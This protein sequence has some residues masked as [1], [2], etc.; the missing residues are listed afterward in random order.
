MNSPQPF[1]RWKFGADYYARST[2]ALQTALDRVP[3]YRSWRAFDPGPA[4]PIDARYAAMPPLT[5]ADIRENFPASILPDDRDMATGL[6]SGEIELVHTSGTTNERITNIWNQAWWDASERASWKLNA[7]LARVATGMHREAILV[8]P[9]NVGFISDDI[10]LPMQKRRLSRFLYLNEKTDTT[11]WSAGHMDRMVEEINSFQ[12]EV[13][14]AN[15]SYLARLCRHISARGLKVV[16]P[17]VIVFTYEYPTRLHY[18]Q[19]REVFTVPMASSY[20]T[21]E[22]GYVFMQC[23]RGNFHQNTEF[24]RVDFQ[25]LK[26]EHGGP[27]L[28]R[29]LVTPLGNPW[30]YLMRFDTGDIVRL[31]DSTSCPCGRGDGM[32]LS[33]I[34]GRTA[35]LTLTAEG[36]LVTLEELDLALSPLDGIDEYQLVQVA[37]ARY[38]L[39]LV[40]LREDRRHLAAQAVE[41]LRTLYGKNADISVVFEPAIAPEV[42]GK[43]LV[44]KALTPV[45]LNRYLDPQYAMVP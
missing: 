30:S 19:I 5:K 4:F 37:G 25:P 2:Q 7:D 34:A 42:S 27:S 1:S 14:E 10:D 20:G 18:R 35:N 29:I 36:R 17:G 11:A 40:T 13:L 39:H 16:Q 38:E 9:R 32:L 23:E 44:S 26:P 31:N 28:G 8:S 24:C 33:S 22:T 43:Y 12:P 6:A 21:T 45:D 41:L 15:P 3:L